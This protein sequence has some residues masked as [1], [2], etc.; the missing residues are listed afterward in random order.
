MVNKHKKN[1]AQTSQKEMPIKT[2]RHR[3]TL[4]RKRIMNSDED[5]RTLL[6]VD[7]GNKLAKPLWKMLVNTSFNTEHTHTHSDSATLL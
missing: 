3:Y 6:H 1:G 2:T 7:N 4:S 5:G